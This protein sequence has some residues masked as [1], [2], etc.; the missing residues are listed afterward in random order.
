MISIKAVSFMFM[1]FMMS[2][3]VNANT[4]E[5]EQTLDGLDSMLRSNPDLIKKLNSGQ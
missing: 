3:L 1:A 2:S 5:S 4:N